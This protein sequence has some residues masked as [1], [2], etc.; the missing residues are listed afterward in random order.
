MPT[1]A[2]RLLPFASADGPGNMGLDEA[3][4]G[5]AADRGAAALRFYGWTTPTLTLGYFQ[6]SELVP[7]RQV[8]SP[9]STDA[10]TAVVGDLGLGTCRLGILPRVRRATGG[11]GIV[12]HHELTYAFALPAGKPWQPA[13]EAWVCRFHH[14]LRDV[15]ATYGVAA[16]AVVCGEE[17]KLGPVLCFLH[18]TPA[19]LTVSGSK[20]AG[21]AQ[22]KLRGALLQHGSILLRQSEH[23]PELPGIAELSGVSIDARGLAD[24]LAAAFAADTGWAVEPGDWTADERAR[25]AMLAADKY[26]SDACNRKR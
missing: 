6:T 14:L 19:D 9:E 10:G 12:H 21:S 17:K 18:Q 23:T 25:A 4:L 24:R 8:S 26:G 20:V 1:P 13:G 2:V 11:A 3:L 16:R 15:L 7:S 22:R 5:S